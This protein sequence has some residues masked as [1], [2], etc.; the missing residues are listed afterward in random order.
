MFTHDEESKLRLLT[1]EGFNSLYDYSIISKTIYT[2]ETQYNEYLNVLRE[3]W[4]FE[5]DGLVIVINSSD[6]QQNINNKWKVDHHNNFAIAIKSPFISKETTFRKIEWNPS[7][8]GNIVPTGIFDEIDINGVK[9]QRATL[10]NYENVVK[11]NLHEGDKIIVARR[12]DV[13]PCIEKNLTKHEEKFII[14]LENI[15]SDCQLK[16][17]MR[18]GVHLVCVNK[19]CP[20]Q[21][22]QQIVY[23]CEEMEIDNIS[24]STIRTLYNNEIVLS[25]LDLYEIEDFY[26]SI[27][28][29]EGFGD[30][31]YD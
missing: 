17:I 11:L 12:N 4:L 21:K 2:I 6:L 22:I 13:I 27:M 10:N 14:P 20:E 26:E 29:L 16:N 9:I 18:E 1:A 23:W 5:T 30:R 19:D 3:K 24:E 8:L 31:K 25:I 15:C 7:R 28:L